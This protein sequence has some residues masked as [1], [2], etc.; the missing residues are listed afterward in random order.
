VPLA[1]AS[2]SAAGAASKNSFRKT[3]PPAL[4]LYGSP[5]LILAARDL[6]K[7]VMV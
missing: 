6:R 2:P 1:V 5:R 7:K 4:G 3:T